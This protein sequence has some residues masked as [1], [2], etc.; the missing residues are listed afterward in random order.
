MQ[1]RPLHKNTHK[2]NENN[3]HLPVLCHRYQSQTGILVGQYY[4]LISAYHS[5]ISVDD[6][7]KTKQRHDLSLR[8][9]RDLQIVRLRAISSSATLIHKLTCKEN[10]SKICSFKCE[11][12]QIYFNFL[13][14]K[15]QQLKFSGLL[16]GSQADQFEIKL[17]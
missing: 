12:D 17:A 9:G 2:T 10:S 16:K 5:F 8:Q 15:L 14:T 7:D 11:N 1:G 4:Q 3:L 13:E 6:Q